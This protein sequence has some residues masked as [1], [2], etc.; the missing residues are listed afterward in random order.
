MVNNALINTN[1][2]VNTTQTYKFT[3]DGLGHVSAFLGCAASI[4][5]GL[6]GLISCTVKLQKQKSWAINFSNH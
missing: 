6:K 5:A 3:D 4:T 2:I 1:T